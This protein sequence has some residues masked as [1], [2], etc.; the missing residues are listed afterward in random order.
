MNVFHGVEKGLTFFRQKKRKS[1]SV[2]H[3]LSLLSNARRAVLIKI[4][5]LFKQEWI[6]IFLIRL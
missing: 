5:G 3:G 1:E 6:I 2:M 4:T